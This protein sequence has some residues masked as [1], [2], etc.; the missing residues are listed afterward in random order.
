MA[1]SAAR[2]ILAAVL[3]LLPPRLF[4]LVLGHHRKT[5]LFPATTPLPGAP[6]D[7][8]PDRSSCGPCTHWQTPAREDVLRK[9]RPS[10]ASA[11]RKERSRPLARWWRRGCT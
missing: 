4:R 3:I 5:L 7:R 11:D 9:L 2:G 6:G 10:R 8:A 1:P